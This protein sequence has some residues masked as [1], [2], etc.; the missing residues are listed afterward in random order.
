MRRGREPRKMCFKK[1]IKKAKIE[2]KVVKKVQPGLINSQR[3]RMSEEKILAY[4]GRGKTNFGRGGGVYMLTVP[5]SCKGIILLV[6]GTGWA[7]EV[8]A[9]GPGQAGQRE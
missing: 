7:G 5:E 8:Q 6:V 9:I 4:R 2:V 3:N 1:K